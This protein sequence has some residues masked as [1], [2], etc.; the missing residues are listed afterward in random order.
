MPHPTGTTARP[1][2]A[3]RTTLLLV[4]S[5]LVA[6]LVPGASRAFADEGDGAAD[7][8]APLALAGFGDPGDGVGSGTLDAEQSTC[9]TVTTK[10]AGLHRVLLGGLPEGY[11]QVYDGDTQIECYDAVWGAGWCDLPRAAAYTVKVV[12]DGWDNANFTVG[13]FPLG[14]TD[15]CGSA[16]S[17]A[18]D[19]QP[20]TGSLPGKV[21]LLCQ[22]FEGRAGERITVDLDLPKYGEAFDWI[23]DGTGAHICSHVDDDNE[24]CVLSGDGPYRVIG[25]ITEIEGG[26][27]ASYTLKVRRISDPAG[28]APAPV[29]SFGAAP[30]PAEDGVGCRTLTVP[31]DGS[32]SLYG[33]SS[34]GARTAL[35]V[36]DH[37]GKTV[38]RGGGDTSLCRLTAG[39]YS[40]FTDRP[41]LILDRAST[42]GCEPAA[43]GTVKGRFDAAG[44]IDCLTLPFPE[45]ARVAVLKSSGSGP[46]PDVTV[47]D[48]A[49]TQRCDYETLSEGTCALAGDGPHRILVSTDDED[50]PTGAYSLTVLRT[51]A[52]NDCRAF[53]AGDF[54]AD[55]PTAAVRTGDGVFATCLTIPAD[56]HSA[57]ENLQLRADTGTT[58][59]AEFS[60][61]DP[62]GKQACSVYASL[63]T[64][65]TCALTP[66]RAY[67]VLVTGRDTAASY[68]LAR[69]DVTADAKGCAAAPATAVGGP[70]TGGDLGAPGTLRC[71]QVTTA[72]AAD[73]LHLNVRDALGTANI[74][75]YKADG[76]NACGYQNKACAV[77]GSTRYQVIET[78]PA[79]LK[80]APS[81][82][83]DALRIA[84]A[85]GPAKECERVPNVS[86]G[87]G[88]LTGTLNEQHTAVCAVLPTASRDT[89][90]TAITDT[91][92]A[93]DTAVPALY[94]SKLANGCSLFIP[95]GYQCGVN[96][97]YTSA[98][99]PTTL[100]LGLPEKTSSTAY[101][102]ELTCWSTLCGTQK[103]DVGVVSPLTGASGSKATLKVTGTALHADDEVRIQLNGKTVTAKTTEV[104]ADRT[105]LTAVLDLTGVAPGAWYLSVVTHN[106]WEYPRGTFTVTAPAAP[107]NTAAPKITGTPKV[108]AKLTA[109]PGAWTPE[110]ASRTYQWQADGKPI[111]GATDATYTVPAELLGK[112]LTVVVT[113]RITGAPSGTAASDAVTVAPGSAPAAVR[114][115]VVLGVLKVGRTLSVAP[116]LWTP[117]PTKLQYRWYADGKAID[118]ATG[119]SLRLTSGQSGK[120]ITVV[121]TAL[122]TGHADGTG[123]TRAT[124][125]VTR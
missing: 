4:L 121:V 11:V 36:Y 74:L 112:K 120:K 93:A 51:D 41:T 71:R 21:A 6:L 102:A 17:T 46:R 31:A 32:Y 44:E 87:Y 8:C 28:C 70:S 57:M 83:L 86:Y 105:S 114:A 62:D 108:G 104:A 67:T 22:T 113:A 30:S 20:V 27:P 90:E 73:V 15:G 122:R 99:T 118:G 40:L 58:A 54:T 80:A 18:W 124:A 111:A 7:P 42:K 76:T 47:V 94:N 78:V 26:F 117:V 60:V 69:R 75:A 37:E 116:G 5:L 98:T 43:S 24:G 61:L 65:T 103:I 88:P 95:D 92:G 16:V 100:V 79:N 2:T 81:Y 66:G 64:W 107:L 84:T 38:C 97:D 14:T 19:A 33:I 53:P 12:N 29:D 119:A 10:A 56:D 63:S 68:S 1:G 25:Q 55:G 48:A 125:A 3:A 34:G 9:F 13:V 82:R 59:A 106:S 23:T 123:R 91:T 110:P 96:E 52:A 45:D 85:D 89:F 49:G 115:P 39:T 72:D 109:G 50:T 35:S 77:T 101:R